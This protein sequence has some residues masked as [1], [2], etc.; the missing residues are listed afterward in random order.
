MLSNE[1]WF[2]AEAGFYPETIDQSLRF[3]D[4]DSPYLLRTPSST[5][6]RKTW[7]VSCWIKICNT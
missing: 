3:E 1:K 4:G 2:G 7:T 5:G 6:N